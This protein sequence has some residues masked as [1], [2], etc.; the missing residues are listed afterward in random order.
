[1]DGR[2]GRKDFMHCPDIRPAKI[3]MIINL[4]IMCIKVPP[5]NVNIMF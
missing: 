3:D 4:L 2:R 5:P 1:M